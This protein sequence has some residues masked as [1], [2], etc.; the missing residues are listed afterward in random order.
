VGD[1]VAARTG[2]ARRAA[3]DVRRAYASLPL[4][5]VENRG[6][7]DPH[8]R[9]YEQSHGHTAAFTRD[10]VFLSLLSTPA[11]PGGPARRQVI[12]LTALGGHAEPQ[13]VAEAPQAARVHSFVGN[14]PARWHSDAATYGSLLYRDVYRGVDL[15]FHGQTQ[16][17]EYDVIV[18]PGADPSI[19][20]LAVEGLRGLSVTADGQLRMELE[21][22]EVLQKAPFVYQDVGGGRRPVPGRFVIQPSLPGARAGES[23]FVYGFVVGDYDRARPLVI[24]PTLFYSSYLG[25]TG[26]DEGVNIS[27]QPGGSAFITGR[28]ASANFD[29]VAGSYDVV[30]NGGV[31]AFVSK[32]EVDLAGVASLV[33]STYLG[34]ANFDEGTGVE[35]RSSNGQIYVTGSTDGGFPTTAG[36]YSNTYA[37][38][39]DTF[40]VR[41]SAAGNALLYST[42]LGGS[43]ID[44]QR[45]MALDGS[46]GHVYI[47]GRTTTA[48]GAGGGDAYVVK[49]NPIG[50]GGSDLVWY[51]FLGGTGADEGNGI[52]VH[53]GGIAYVTGRTLSNNFPTTAGA[54]DTTYNGSGDA[55]VTVVNAAGSAPL[56]STYLGGASSD[57]GFSIS[58]DSTG[59]AYVAG[60]TASNA[61]PTVPGSYATVRNGPSDAFVAKVNRSLAG[62]ASLVYSTYLG[63]TAQDGARGISVGFNGTVCVTGFTQS[64]DFPTVTPLQVANA[65]N[66]DVFMTQLNAAGTALLFSTYLGGAAADTG[67]AVDFT[68]QLCCVVGTTGSANYPAT[69]GAFQAA[70]GGSTD[71]CLTCVSQLTTAVEL[72]RF[73][74]SPRDSSVELTWRTGSELYNLG[75]H[76]Y[77]S[78]TEEGPYERVTAAVIPGLGSSPEGASYRWVDGGLTNGVTYFYKLEDVETTGRTEQHGPVSATPQATPPGGSGEEGSGAPARTTYGDPTSSLR[79]LEQT[80]RHL[81]L[82]LRTRGFH[83]VQQPDGTV[84]LEVPGLEPVLDPGF[85]ALPRKRAVVDAVAGRGVRIGRV[86]ARGVLTFPGLTPAL[87]GTPE[88]V[89]GGGDVI[90]ARV[91]PSLVVRDRGQG[92]FPAEAVR[93]AGTAFQGD[94]KKAVVELWPLRWNAA[95]SR[96]ELARRIVV[97]LEFVGHADREFSLDGGAHGRRAPRVRSF[98]APIAEL[99]VRQRGLHQVRFE[100]LFG[101]GQR[102]LRADQ[103]KLI[104]QGQPVAFHLEPAGAYFARGSSLFFFS[105]GA[106][107]NPYGTEAVYQL[108]PSRD[109]GPVMPL[110]S[111]FPSGD[112][113]PSGRATARWQ[114]DKTFQPGLLDAPDIWLWESMIAPARKSHVFSL[115]GLAATAEPSQVTV[116]LQGGSDQDGVADH[117]VRLSVNG[118]LVGEATW[119]GMA[120]EALSVPIGPGILRE[121]DNV[122]E[123]ESVGDAGATYSLAFLDRFE[124]SY[125]RGLSTAGQAYEAAFS[126][127]GAVE[128]SGLGPDGLLVD[129]TSPATPRWLFGASAAPG[130]L[131]L[132]VEPGRDYLAVPSSAVL[133][134]VVRT[135]LPGTLR[136]TTNRADYLLIAPRSLL[137]AAQPLLDLRA[138]QGLAVRAAALD[139]VF[140]EFGY[141][142]ATPEAIREFVAYAYHSW[143]APS[144]RYVVLLGDA[145]YDYRNLVG[146]GAAN[147]VPPLMV[148]TTF[149]WTASDPAFAAVNGDDLV[150]DLALG[151]LPAANLAE[152]H[153]LVAKIVAFETAGRSLADG[154]AVLV[155]DNPDLAGDFE[156]SAAVAGSLLAPTHA[157]ET[158]FLREL[159]AG[160]RPTIAAA[161]DRGASLVSYLGHGGIAVWAS[162]NVFNNQDVGSL[163]PQDQ[164]PVLLTMDCLNG[165]FHFPFLNSLAEEL[166]KAPGKGAI[167]SFAPSGLS[168]HVPADVYHQALV[169]QLASGG[170]ERLGDAIFAAQVDYAATGALPELLAVYNLLGDPALKIR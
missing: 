53:T 91:R 97:R 34:G 26:A 52:E 19:V 29:T 95:E 106:A 87:S 24:D 168:L 13:I 22:G 125:P 63:G 51:F 50:G 38:A 77:R 156:Q 82:E 155:A 84:L 90:Q 56:Y 148:K 72:M 117:H 133:R 124:V 134:P 103:L 39:R 32:F 102:R 139:E 60:E 88:M 93:L 57:T 143:E 64:I 48:G 113:V 115:P 166:M 112:V 137:S 55:F 169:R 107:L 147:L 150:P 28:T 160:T 162:E 31:D 25:G 54:Y 20:R 154:P 129:V 33:F 99:A 76:L 9:F 47:T 138:A 49:F 167:A 12:R 131:T 27:V 140:Q 121:A 110:V 40:V 66:R 5:F 144:P 108:V 74:A 86:T 62:A 141:G 92:M 68:G 158:V 10:G 163:S 145:S 128:L 127:A 159:G 109:G 161:F 58:V 14:D 104:R 11:A 165:Y 18:Q 4:R 135:P 81:V 3:A 75:F 80:D 146:G 16:H 89:G 94:V 149:L 164:Q 67:N 71:V 44:E 120:V 7:L 37:G 130:G 119:N 96:L 35:V 105:E 42:Y 1:A 98:E 78:L 70:L 6:Q 23:L 142:E 36:A 118:T 132:R 85:P 15:R 170:H 30:A 100:E 59:M 116:F 61:F 17:L 123:L 157:V 69:A 43:G 114:Q 83:A 8:I 153:A 126:R 136:R 101:T 122:L 2:A 152:A 41:L 151:R 111:A 46:T 65:G 21:H 45:D 73:E 79:I